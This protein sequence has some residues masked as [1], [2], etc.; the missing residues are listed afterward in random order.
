MMII[1]SNDSELEEED[2]CR[3]NKWPLNVKASDLIT[4]KTD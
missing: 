4:G 1:A 2:Y 3:P